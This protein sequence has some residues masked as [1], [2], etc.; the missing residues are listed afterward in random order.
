MLNIGMIGLGNAG[1]QVA[2]LAYS[3]RNIPAIAINSSER[4]LSTITKVPKICFGKLGSGKD[5]NIAKQYIKKN[6][7]ELLGDV[8]FSDICDK[9]IVFIVS[10]TGGGSGSGIAPML[11]DILSSYH[12]DTKFILVGIL[13]EIRESFAAQTNSSEYLREMI[14]IENITYML[15]DNNT[16]REIPSKN[17]LQSVN[18][19][20][21]EDMV[22][23]RGEYQYLTP[24]NSID[25]QDML[26]IISTE[27]MI[28][29]SKLYGFKEKDLDGKSIDEMLVDYLKSESYMCELDR[30]GVIK[31]M[32]MINNLSDKLMN[33]LD[34][35]LPKLKELVGEPI[36]GFEH[37]YIKMDVQENKVILILS[38][39]STP[40]DR[41]EKILQRIQEI[42]DGISNRVGKDNLLQDDDETKEIRKDSKR[43]E[44]N[45]NIKDIMG[46]YFI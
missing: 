36:E 9:D 19:E 27:G 23:I 43:D 7:K 33:Q 13:P 40:N 21:V 15:Y 3:E 26:K 22:I 44:D 8:T 28:N 41:I 30:D 39:L 42:K 25:E 45:V 4:D 31:R 2:E 16:N 35:K 18:K 17:L 34:K 10:S 6:I 32:G 46:K 29:I 24:L 12:Q 1:N 20:I 11:Y 5:R 37:D 38:G 14:A